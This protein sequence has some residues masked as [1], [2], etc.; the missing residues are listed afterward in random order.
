MSRACECLARREHLVLWD[1]HVAHRR[2]LVQART[3]AADDAGEWNTTFDFDVTSNSV[4]VTVWLCL[5]TEAGQRTLG[6]FREEL[7]LRPGVVS[8]A[9][10][11][12]L[13]KAL[14]TDPKPSAEVRLGMRYSSRR[15][16]HAMTIQDFDILSVIG[17]GSFGKVMVVRKL[18]TQRIYAMKVLKKRELQERGGETHLPA[19][20]SFRSLQLGGSPMVCSLVSF[21][22]SLLPAPCS[23][24]RDPRPA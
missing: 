10:W 13:N 4:E 20:P 19:I 12:S 1:P 8:P 9:S 22:C 21:D 6:T 16:P 15:N 3:G 23:K 7:R 18:D 2:S 5:E 24:R 14:P 11:R 17:Q